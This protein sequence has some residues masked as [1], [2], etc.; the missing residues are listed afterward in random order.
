[1][2][3]FNYDISIIKIEK[4]IG[5]LYLYDLMFKIVFRVAEMIKYYFDD[6]VD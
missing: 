6:K 5:Y 2:K 3:M 1:M 4:N